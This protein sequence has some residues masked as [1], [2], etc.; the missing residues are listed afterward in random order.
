MTRVGIRSQGNKHLRY[1]NMACIC[2][3]RFMMIRIH[4]FQRQLHAGPDSLLYL[5][6]TFYLLFH[7]VRKAIFAFISVK[8]GLDILCIPFGLDIFCFSELSAQVPCVYVHTG[9]VLLFGLRSLAS[10]FLGRVVND[11]L[12]GMPTSI[13]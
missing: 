5:V 6:N 3:S 7:H 12:L 9:W 13:V 8:G 1:S 11:F 10:V 4:F 2:P